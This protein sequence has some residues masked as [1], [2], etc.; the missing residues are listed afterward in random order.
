MKITPLADVKARLVLAHSPRFQAVLE[1][2]R[3][4]I[5]AGKGLARIALWNAVAERRRKKD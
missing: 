3:A 2:S 4:T 5:G 1:E